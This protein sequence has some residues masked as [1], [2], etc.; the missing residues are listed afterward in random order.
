MELSVSQ[1]LST[2]QQPE[3]ITLDAVVDTA[4]ALTNRLPMLEIEQTLEKMFHFIEPKVDKL[5]GTGIARL[6]GIIYSPHAESKMSL[7]KTHTLFEKLLQ[8]MSNEKSFKKLRFGSEDIANLFMS[9]RKIHLD[10]RSGDGSTSVN[11]RAVQNLVH[12]FSE[13]AAWA[14]SFDIRLAIDSL[15]GMDVF[16]EK[17]CGE[18]MEE[19]GKRHEKREWPRGYGDIASLVYYA[20]NLNYEHHAIWTFAQIRPA[21]GTPSLHIIKALW[22]FASMDIQPVF[23][24]QLFALDPVKLSPFQKVAWTE[25]VH[26]IQTSEKLSHEGVLGSADK[27]KILQEAALSQYKMHRLNMRRALKNRLH[28]DVDKILRSI[29]KTVRTDFLTALGPIDHACW[30]EGQGL[31]ESGTALFFDLGEGHQRL[32]I[33]PR[34]TLKRTE[35]VRREILKRKGWTILSVNLEGLSSEEDQA[36]ALY[37]VLGV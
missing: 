23:F 14:T 4:Y 17:L 31:N 5:D 18:I 22:S 13:Q 16:D 8:T 15:A 28:L 9:F 2:A 33:L 30:S 3:S 11:L 6:F 19:L 29:F 35:A 7:L 21:N 20:A 1:G 24:D 37:R 27:R 34:G 26:L 32:N 10:L 25:I 12:R 36:R